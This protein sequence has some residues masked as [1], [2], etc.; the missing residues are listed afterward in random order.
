MKQVSSDKYNV[1][2]FRLA[3]CVSRGEKERALGVYR[4]LSHSIADPALMQQLEGDLYLSFDDVDS[5]I[6]RYKKAATLYLQSHRNVEG[7]A[8]YEHLILLEPHNI[9]NLIFLIN[10]Y[11]T[12]GITTKVLTCVERAIDLFVCDSTKNLQQFL[13]S[14]QALSADYYT[15]AHTYMCTDAKHVK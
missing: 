7:A 10:V 2:W 8:L 9:D 12:I 13:L 11:H 4:L 14:L 3:E 1:A 6:A 15:H 5:A